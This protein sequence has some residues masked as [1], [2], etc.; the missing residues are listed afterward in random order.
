MPGA[1]DP[2]PRPSMID[3]RYEVESELGIGGMGI[4]LLA[5]DPT[6]N[7]NVAVKLLRPE[8]HQ[9]EHAGRAA[10]RLVRAWQERARAWR[11]DYRETL[12]V[13]SIWCVTHPDWSEQTSPRRAATARRS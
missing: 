12:L 3:G 5:Y 1:T 6:L 11:V 2:P 10:A 8:L 4:V 7:R 13:P 9:G